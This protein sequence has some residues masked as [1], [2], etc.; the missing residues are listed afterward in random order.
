MTTP[1]P[2]MDLVV[3]SQ[4]DPFV[5]DDLAA[6]WNKIDRAPGVYPC[7]SSTRPAWNAAK[8]GRTIFETD[9]GLE[10]W[11]TGG[12]W[13]RKSAYGLLRRN[14]GSRAIAARN[15]AYA[16]TSSGFSV[17]LALTGVVVPD[18]SRP[19]RLDA[20]YVSAQTTDQ[21]NNTFVAL[22]GSA[23]NGAGATFGRWALA[24]GP[25][26]G[27]H[28]NMSGGSVSAFLAGGLPPGVYDFS[29]QVR[30]Y[31]NGK[32]VTLYGDGTSPMTLACTEL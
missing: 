18:G 12:G 31:T 14:D 27:G 15:S 29:L 10:W 20:Y 19:L 17:A 2:R 6:N 23:S 16:T 24:P 7:T 1:S 30:A 28:S 26:V 4:A 11:W 5:T 25:E 13:A 32:T 8:A 21:P 3:P 22:M 9:T